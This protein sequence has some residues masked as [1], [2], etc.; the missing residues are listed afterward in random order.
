[1]SV[2]SEGNVITKH[3]L[4]AE[5]LSE[6]EP[7][8]FAAT[9]AVFE[10]SQLT[11]LEAKRWHMQLFEVAYVRGILDRY[12]GNVSKAAEA[13][14][15]DRKTFYRLLK[16]HHLQ[17]YAFHRIGA[18]Q[19][20]K[21]MYTGRRY[22]PSKGRTTVTIP[23]LNPSG[24]AVDGSRGINNAVKNFSSRLSQCCKGGSPCGSQRSPYTHATNEVALRAT[25]ALGVRQVSPAVDLWLQRGSAICI[26]VPAFGFFPPFLPIST[27]HRYGPQRGTG[28]AFVKGKW[29]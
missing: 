5:F 18:Q 25:V 15:V 10:P 27:N 24:R 4:P 17:P 6:E 26:A 1:M 13:A 8:V 16:K 11:F 9:P 29:E 20:L 23:V 3:D 22:P 19:V 21:S 28:V 7:P 14:D 2:L 12:A